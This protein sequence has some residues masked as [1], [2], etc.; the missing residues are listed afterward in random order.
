MANRVFELLKT[1]NTQPI[2]M[3]LKRIYRRKNKGRKTF[4][5]H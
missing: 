4:L 2:N 3:F 1:I 5:S